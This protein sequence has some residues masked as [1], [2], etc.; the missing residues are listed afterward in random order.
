V[1]I[2]EVVDAESERMR[3]AG[4]ATEVVLEGNGTTPAAPADSES[5]FKSPTRFCAV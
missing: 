5:K 2:E 4:S 3:V 1:R